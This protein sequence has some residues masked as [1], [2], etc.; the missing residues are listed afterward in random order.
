MGN[1]TNTV[2]RA[3]F[4]SDVD[5]HLR[6]Q[7]NLRSALPVDFITVDADGK[8]RDANNPTIGAY[9]YV[10]ISEETPE[11]AEGYPVVSGITE[12]SADVKTKW[13]VS[14]KLYSQVVKATEPEQ[15]AAAA[16]RKAPTADDLKAGSAQSV[17]ADNEVTTTFSGLDDNTK[18]EVYF[19]NVSALGKESEVVKAE[20]TTARYIAPL[21]A[22]LPKVTDTIAAG[23]QAV[24]VPAVAGGDLPYTYEWRDQM[25]QVV[26]TGS[27]LTVKPTQS[28][29]Y[30]LTVTSA[31]G[32]TAKAKTGVYVEGETL[33]GTFEDNYLAD[34]SFF[35]GDNAD[36]EFYTGSYA[37]QVGNAIWPGSTIS[38]WYGY[39]LSNQTSTEYKVLDDQ[40][41]A[42]T[43]G[44]MESKNFAIAYPNGYGVLVTNK[45]EGDT[46]PGMYV[47]NTAYAYSSMTEGDGYARAFRKGDYLKVTA[48][49]TT[50]T[51]TT[52]STDF[53]LGDAQAEQAADRYVLNTWEWIDLRPLGKVKKVTFTF[54]GTDVGTY[55]LNTP[56]YFAIDNFGSMPIA[57]EAEKTVNLGVSEIDLADLFEHADNGATEVYRLDKPLTDEVMDVT[58]GEAGKLNV[59]SRT[60]PAALCLWP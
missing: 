55:G 17:T 31:D 50:A 48:T 16:P 25:N 21:E 52:A 33:M 26:G 37:F 10:E 42:I 24:L 30:R 41:H 46:I 53:Y 5:L 20:F 1:T 56:T 45:E 13:T 51:G 4:L 54:T 8:E 6:A 11:I 43:G 9:E 3:Q 57:A 32:Q 39:A 12:N 2:E 44:G 60:K 49:G 58:L 38:F 35:N 7:G 27:I 40:Y 29:A 14:G 19:L 18:Y 22:S 28:Y 47:T 15:G 23:E 34:E 59:N 36:D